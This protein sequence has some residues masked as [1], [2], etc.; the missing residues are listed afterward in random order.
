AGPQTDTAPNSSS[1][2]VNG[3]LIGT[4]DILGAGIH[5][6]PKALDAA[7]FALLD[8]GGKLMRTDFNLPAQRDQSVEL[9]SRV[10][11][12]TTS[13]RTPTVTSTGPECEVLTSDSWADRAWARL[14]KVLCNFWVCTNPCPG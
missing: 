14:R 9:R 6:D 12:Q 2:F 10:V 13:N 8:S 1:W 11:P 7:Q 5:A 3:S 4:Q